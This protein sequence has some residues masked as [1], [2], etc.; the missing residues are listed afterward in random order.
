MHKRV[1]IWRLLESHGFPAG[2][3]LHKGFLRWLLQFVLEILSL[4]LRLL[5]VQYIVAPL[6]LQVLVGFDLLEGLEQQKDLLKWW[7]LL[8][9]EL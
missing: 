3:H 8:W 9:L 1:G 7:H 4:F 5:S 6:P 2:L